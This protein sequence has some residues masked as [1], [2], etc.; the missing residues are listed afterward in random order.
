MLSAFA[1]ILR[2]T[3]E[4]WPFYL[5][6]TI[7]GIGAATT[8]LL[9]PYL[10]KLA[11]D[12]IVD[13]LAGGADVSGALRTIVW[14]MI[15]LLIVELSHTLITNIGGW[16]GDIMAMRMRQILSDRYFAKLLGLPQRYYDAQVTGTIISRLDRSVLALTDFLKSFAN[17][18]LSMLLTIGMILVITGW[19]Y[20]PLALLLAV[21]FPLYLYLT[22]LSS[23]RWMVWEQEKNDH[24]DQAQG[25]FAE[26]IGQIKVVKSFQTELRELRQFQ[27]HFAATIS[28]T[29]SQ[30]R[31]WHVHDVIRMGSLN[32]TF[33]VIYL[34]LFWKTLRGDF[35]IG[36]LVLLLQYVTMARQPT[37]M[38]SWLVDSAQR[39]ASGSKAYFKAMAE[40]PEPGV[41]AV[42]LDAAAPGGPLLVEDDT[43]TASSE[44][45]APSEDG[46]AIVFDG[47]NF[48]YVEGEP[49]LRDI[50]FRARPGESVALVGESGGGKSTIVNL[51][52]GLYPPSSGTL[53]V[54]GRE[55][56]DMNTTDLRSAVGVV[57][58]EPA[59][60]SGTIRENIA[61]ARPGA[62]D[63]E[64]EAVARRADAHGFISEFADGYDTVIG[65]RG[66]RLSGGQ[67]QRIAVARAMLKDAPVLILDEA[68]SA[69]DTKAERMVQASLE[70]LMVG[71]TTIVI[72]HRLSTI[73]NVDTIVTLDHGCIS[74]I[75]S[76]AELATSGGIYSELLA[77]TASDKVADRE[78][79]KRFGFAVGDDEDEDEA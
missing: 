37:F 33:F 70:K 5:A 48:S 75:G 39:A 61:Y 74:E 50:T 31:W 52:L 22:T 41:P 36:D 77:L 71:R 79:L 7:A 64:I 2:T 60:F 16:F 62:T 24:I 13:T 46:D 28:L 51:L 40:T 17:S 18:F 26:V 42:L 53:S 57:F 3:R 56:S 38:M 73:A 32:I 68:T 47:V 76:P 59:L 9:T 45:L 55:V 69:L 21:I 1:R 49:V 23:K 34:L 43:T 72:A 66:L 20:W 10:V 15:C 4:L 44:A 54:C 14:L 6:V 25:R 65:E 67:K 30:S 19:Y 8:A 35:T 78:R 11:T 27:Q 29:K 63:A 58:Q 12:T